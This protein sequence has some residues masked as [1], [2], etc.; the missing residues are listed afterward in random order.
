M[1][2][3][4]NPTNIIR[5]I[6]QDLKFSGSQR[7][8]STQTFFKY[9]IYLNSNIFTKIKRYLIKYLF[10]RDA[11]DEI[12]DVTINQSSITRAR[13]LIALKPATPSG[14]KNI[15]NMLS[16]KKFYIYFFSGLQKYLSQNE[17]RAYATCEL[18]IENAGTDLE[19][20]PNL[21]YKDIRAGIRFVAHLDSATSPRNEE[22]CHK[23]YRG[24]RVLK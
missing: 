19:N 10:F 22:E 1:V 7:L 12:F 23:L 24:L 18:M 20:E 6:F 17:K 9:C 14:E 8:F 4:I 15:D 16:K 2:W 11:F 21:A 3:L 13:A 5:I